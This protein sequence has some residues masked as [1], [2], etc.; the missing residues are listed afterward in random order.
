M[1]RPSARVN[2]RH[3][4]FCQHSSPA[5]EGSHICPR[6]SRKI[7]RG[8]PPM[9]GRVLRHER[10]VDAALGGS[11]QFEKERQ[12]R[13]PRL[14]VRHPP[15]RQLGAKT[16]NHRGHQMFPQGV[17]SRRGGSDFLNPLQ[18]KCFHP[19]RA[20]SPRSARV[21]G[22]RSA[23]RR[24]GRWIRR[25]HRVLDWCR[26]K[27]RPAGPA[28]SPRQSGRTIH[29]RWSSPPIPRIPTSAVNQRRG[30]QSRWTVPDPA[31][32]P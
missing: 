9:P 17:R 8:C 27:G 6:L 14:A 7:G 29:S 25:E 13:R 28:E 24:Y 2:F 10:S 15:L 18:P 26:S 32:P 4:L 3:R 12:R 30:S 11:G 20:L 19:D 1:R 23:A 5:G 31:R 16:S 21:S 22:R